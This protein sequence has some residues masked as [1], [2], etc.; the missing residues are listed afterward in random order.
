MN[1]L[2]GPVAKA[3]QAEFLRE[4]QHARL[5]RLARQNRAIPR[6]ALRRRRR[7]LFAGWVFRRPAPSEVL[8]DVLPS[9]IATGDQSLVCSPTSSTPVPLP[10][11]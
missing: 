5:V 1:M 9:T 3:R 6:M 11:D 10:N 8:L 2:H 4:A 7:Q